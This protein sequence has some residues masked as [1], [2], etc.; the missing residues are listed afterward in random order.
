MKYYEIVRI[1]NEG[2][3][4]ETFQDI[5]KQA[6]R[7]WYRK[8]VEYLSNWDYGDE[9]LTAAISL[10]ELRDNVLDSPGDNVL[11]E[12]GDYTLCKANDITGIYEAYYL[13]KAVN[14]SEI[15]NL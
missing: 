4:Q 7:G 11:Y 8:V 15:E 14:E 5:H 1:A 3:D 6:R 13:V 9:N 10:N 2:P 12:K